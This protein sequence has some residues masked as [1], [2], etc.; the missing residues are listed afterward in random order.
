MYSVPAPLGAISPN[1]T[2]RGGEGP[3][4]GSS[5]SQKSVNLFWE[6]GLGGSHSIDCLKSILCY[7]MYHKFIST[8]AAQYVS[9]RLYVSV[10][11]L[12]IQS[13]LNLLTGT[14]AFYAMALG[15]SILKRPIRTLHFAFSAKPIT[16]PYFCILSCP[17]TSH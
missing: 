11:G 10:N 13:C 9:P 2:L 7:D 8:V 4:A 6:R 1:T 14:G 15:K 17:I 12:K 5:L 3:I 16:S